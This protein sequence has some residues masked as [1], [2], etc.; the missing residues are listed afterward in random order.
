MQNETQNLTLN[1]K[2]TSFKTLTLNIKY[3]TF[4]TLT[5]KYT[6]IGYT[7][8]K[9]LGYLANTLSFIYLTGQAWVYIK[10]ISNDGYESAT[11][12]LT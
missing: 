5:L 3:T 7:P 4:K 11:G 1:I 10:I 2:Y 8:T 6:T 9:I 12:A